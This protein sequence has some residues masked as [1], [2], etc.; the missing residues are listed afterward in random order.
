MKWSVNAGGGGGIRKR[1]EKITVY[2]LLAP[3]HGTWVKGKTTGSASSAKQSN[4]RQ[5]LSKHAKRIYN[6]ARYH[7]KVSNNKL[8]NGNFGKLKENT[9][10][11]RDRTVLFVSN[12]TN[13]PILA[14]LLWAWT[15][16]RIS[17]HVPPLLLLA[18]A[19][20]V[21]PSQVHDLLKMTENIAQ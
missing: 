21:R 1:K 5:L 14:C 11:L 6:Q 10:A 16:D 13:I 8:D 4:P 7:T 20:V 3:R 9:S 18:F 19:L 17:W 15:A 2:T 12:K